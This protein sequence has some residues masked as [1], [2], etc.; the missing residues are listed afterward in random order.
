MALGPRFPGGQ[1]GTELKPPVGPAGTEDAVPV[2][3][4]RAKRVSVVRLPQDGGLYSI[5]ARK[6]P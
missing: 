6:Q 2:H 5:G 3:G 1:V 4:R